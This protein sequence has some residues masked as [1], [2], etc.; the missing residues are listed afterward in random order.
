MKLFKLLKTALRGCWFYFWGHIFSLFYYD[1]KYLTGKWFSG[2]LGGLCSLG[3]EWVA[4]NGFNRFLTGNNKGVKIPVSSNI[5]ISE[6]QNII[7]HPDDLNNFQTFGNYY[8]AFGKITIGQGT[9]IAPNV[10]LITSNHDF[11]NLDNHLPPQ[12]IVIGKNCWIGINS[13]ILPGVTL[14]DNTTVGAGSVVTKSF[15]EGRCVIAGNPA[16]IIKLIDD[17]TKNTL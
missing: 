15:T 10:G 17:N 16:K 11:S 1:K 3:W 8:Q 6:A 7:F 13:V 9:Y 4:K 14:G 2:K 12:P 5:R